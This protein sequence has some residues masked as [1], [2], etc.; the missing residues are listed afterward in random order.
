MPLRLSYALLVGFGLVLTWGLDV[1]EIISHASR[2]FA[3]YY[4]IQSAIAAL[5]AWRERRLL[6]SAGFAAMAALGL[7]IT[8]FGTP[9][10]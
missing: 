4:A 9:V 5:G 1:F 7:A 2:A 10:E 3:A 8:V 6:L